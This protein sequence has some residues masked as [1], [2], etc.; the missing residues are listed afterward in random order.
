MKR[1]NQFILIGVIVII[2][3]I[4]LICKLLDLRTTISENHIGVKFEIHNCSRVENNPADLRENFLRPLLE[5]NIVRKKT[6]TIERLYLPKVASL[7]KEFCIP[8]IGI[9]AVRYD[10]KTKTLQES[11]MTST[12]RED[13]QESFF[14][15][16]N[17]GDK[18]NALEKTL[19][20]G[21]PEV[22]LPSLKQIKKIDKLDMI[23]IDSFIIDKNCSYQVIED[24]KPYIF[25]STGDLRDYINKELEKNPNALEKGTVDKTIHIF[26]YCGAGEYLLN[27]NDRDNDGVNNEFDDCPDLPGEKA[28]KG[29]PIKEDRDGDGICDTEDKCPDVRGDRACDGCVC[30]PCADGDRDGICD[31]KDKCPDLF[32]LTKNGCP[33]AP[34]PPKKDKDKD[35][36]IDSEDNCPDNAGPNENN[37]CP[38]AD[39][40]GILDKDDD[41]PQIPGN[42]EN[43]GCPKITHNNKIGKFMVPT[44]IKLNEFEVTMNIKQLNGNNVQHPFEG[45]TSPTKAE[46]NKIINL[47]SN[48][49][50][51]VITITIKDKNNPDIFHRQIFKNMSMICFTDKSCGFVDLDRN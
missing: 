14:S 45:Y 50:D 47:L 48:P 17:G 49:V 18:L 2:I 7:D 24:N 13:D 33:K 34:T 42:Q 4:F 11:T 44:T 20:K 3:F 32:G 31:D 19:L 26:T 43:K 36:I 29:C 16:W 21:N 39:A 46:S 28:N 35:G 1:K 25:K 37:G 9:N 10:S 51:L 38:D 15:S 12:S 41:C 8:A 5:Y 6:E 22:K 23:F 30:P 40:D 27:K